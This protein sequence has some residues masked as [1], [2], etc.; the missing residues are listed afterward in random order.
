MLS[1]DDVYLVDSGPQLFVWL[2]AAASSRERAAAFN[3]ASTYLKTQGKPITTPVSVLKEGQGM[4]NSVFKT[5]FA[6]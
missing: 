1:S 4:R 2:G 5:I 3:T 6:N